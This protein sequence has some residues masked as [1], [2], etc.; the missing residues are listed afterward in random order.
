MSRLDELPPDHS[1]AL[2]LLLRQRKSYAQVAQ[3][4]GIDEHAVHDRA[5]AALVLLAPRRARELGAAERL[6]VGDYLLGQQ[7]GVAER[8]RART[9]LASSE[10]ARAWASELAALLAP[11]A[12]GALP[13]IPAASAA[14]APAREPQRVAELFAAAGMPGPGKGTAAT[15]TGAAAAGTGAAA[16]GTGGAA[17]GGAGAPRSSRTAGAVLL[18][19]LAAAVIVAVVLITNG[20]SSHPKKASTT[21]SS[22]TTTTTTSKSKGPKVEDQITLKPS[23]PGNKIIAVVYVL[24]EGSKR[25]FFIAAQNLPETKHFYYAIWLYDSPTHFLALSRSPAVGHSH[26][27]AG[28][29]ALPA[30]AG[31]FH[32][33]LL[34]E[35]TKAHPTH[36]GLVIMH[37][38]FKAG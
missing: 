16:A 25:A 13:E 7:P 35:E 3:L 20:G 34:T 27:L 12:G 4:L 21:A 15:S 2:S 38:S 11:L 30:N 18:A 9:L 8:L 17:A 28:G 33:I 1:A 6:E 24:A 19:V 29:S 23:H 26:S 36:P 10:P 31:E 37:G 32:E 14:G 22:S 5:H